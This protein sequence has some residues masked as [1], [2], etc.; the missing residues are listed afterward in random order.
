[1]FGVPPD[2]MLNTAPRAAKFFE[3]V[4]AEGVAAPPRSAED[5]AG[6]A[7]ASGY[8]LRAEA[9]F[10]NEHGGAIARNKQYF[11]YK[12]LDEL[13][14]NHPSTSKGA[15]SAEDEHESRACLLSFCGGLLAISP[16][17]RWT[18]RQVIT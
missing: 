17:E 18:P 15:A 12:T 3:R 9:D 4:G 6:S 14:H 2:E 11:K 5:A 13:I 7:G 8:K 10:V 1:M 16:K